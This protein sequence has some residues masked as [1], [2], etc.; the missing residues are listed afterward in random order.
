MDEKQALPIAQTWVRPTIQ[1]GF[2]L[3]SVL[4][5]LEFRRFVLSL[6]EPSTGPVAHRPP[7]VEAYLPI[8]SLMS[9][10]HWAKSA[11]ERCRRT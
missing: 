11:A 5:G 7:A 1:I 2:V 4:I 3:A 9:L 8:S 6:A 10:T